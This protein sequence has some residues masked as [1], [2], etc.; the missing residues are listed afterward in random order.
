MEPN[1]LIDQLDEL[2]VM[3]AEEITIGN[4]FHAFRY[5]ANF[6]S[7]QECQSTNTD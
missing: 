3:E 1:G 7:E 4:A 5:S 2:D 6:V